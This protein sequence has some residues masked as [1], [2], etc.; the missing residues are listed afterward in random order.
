MKRL[1]THPAPA[2]PATAT[3]D[4]EHA[5][6][7]GLEESFPASDP[8]AID[9]EPPPQVQPDGIQRRNSL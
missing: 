4:I 8:V 7:V 9:I 1:P 3:D 2:T 5:L 6:D